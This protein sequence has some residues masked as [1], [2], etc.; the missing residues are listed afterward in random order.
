MVIVDATGK[1]YTTAKQDLRLAELK[2]R[3]K[4][5]LGQEIT[6]AMRNS[7]D[8]RINLNMQLINSILEDAYFMG[9]N[10]A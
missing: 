3:F 6:R 9:R 4:Q 5:A 2:T 8:G 10:D 7:R 1:Q